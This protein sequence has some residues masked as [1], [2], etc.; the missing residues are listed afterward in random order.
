[1][2]HRLAVNLF[3]VVGLAPLRA[4]LA[5]TT[6]N[7]GLRYWYPV[8]AASPP[9]V[10]KVDVCVYG[11]TPGGVAA[12][13]QARRMG[14]SAVLVVFRRHVGGLTSAGLTAVDLGKKESI[15]GLAAEFL[16]RVGRWSGFR[17]SQAEHT[18]RA[19]LDEA[20]V[21]VL[22]EHRLRDVAKEGNRLR[23]RLLADRQKL[24][25]ETAAGAT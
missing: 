5:P 25:W 7:P 11:G 23:A 19:L 2:A 15:G 13:V 8:P 22:F 14:K 20:K 24:V 1:V 12:A 21:P 16:Q 6:P 3:L 4:E 9:Q 17:P 18:F 10:H